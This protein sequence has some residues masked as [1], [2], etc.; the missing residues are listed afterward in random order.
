[1]FIFK[2]VNSKKE[3]IRNLQLEHQG[4]EVNQYVTLSIGIAHTYCHPGK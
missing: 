3:N 1:M 4:S 2:I